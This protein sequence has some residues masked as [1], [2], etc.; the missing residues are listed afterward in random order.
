[1]EDSP[2]KIG[3]LYAELA[4]EIARM[5]GPDNEQVL[6]YVEVGDMWT[7]ISLYKNESER[8]SYI[9]ESVADSNLL[10]DIIF[11]IWYAEAPDKRWKEMQLDVDGKKFEA[12]QFY[13]DQLNKRESYD[14]RRE[15][16]V[17]ERFGDKPIYYSP[18]SMD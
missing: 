2:S 7:G 3:D 6:L 8:V 9:D 14:D 1:M 12:R 10:S 5:A 11:D 15:R 17:R 4:H 13:A 16:A 18:L